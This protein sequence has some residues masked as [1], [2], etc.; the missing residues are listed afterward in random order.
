MLQHALRLL[1]SL[2]F[3]FGLLLPIPLSTSSYLG[4]SLGPYLA[5]DVLSPPAME[6]PAPDETCPVC[7]MFVARH[8][9][10]LARIVFASGPT[11]FFDGPK[12]LFRYLLD[13]ERYA[14]HRRDREITGI[15]VTAY[16]DGKV[17]PVEEA[18][19]VVGSDVV[20]PMGPELVPHGSREE[21][22]EFLRD[23]RGERIVRSPEVT[24]EMLARPR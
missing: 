18:W 10:W 19:F 5:A 2:S 23:H 4:S 17:L 22:E 13:P 12:D 21:A 9:E 1:M 24:V 20:G 11:A 16:Y 8:P 15:F 3:P 7:G 14:A 6:E